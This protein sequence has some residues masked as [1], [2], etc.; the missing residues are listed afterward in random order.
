MPLFAPGELAFWLGGNHFDSS[1]HGENYTW[2]YDTFAQR[3]PVVVLEEPRM[4][5]AR[6]PYS[7]SLPWP[8]VRVLTP[9]GIRW[10]NNQG[11]ESN[12]R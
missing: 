4:T 11:L 3:V 2:D 6:V 8:A 7:F 12:P 9:F 10:V 5:R 1:P